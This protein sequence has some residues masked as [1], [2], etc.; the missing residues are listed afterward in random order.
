MTWLQ[1]PGSCYP[2]IALQVQCGLEHVQRVREA[3]ARYVARTTPMTEQLWAARAPQ[4]V[5]ARH[6]NPHPVGKEVVML[7]APWPA[8]TPGRQANPLNPAAL[9]P[10]IMV[11]GRRDG[12]RWK[13][14]APRRAPPA[15]LRS[16]APSCDGP[17]TSSADLHLC[18]YG[19]HEH[20]MS[21]SHPRWDR[22]GARWPDTRTVFPRRLDHPTHPTA[23][24]GFFCPKGW[25]MY[26]KDGPC[27]CI[28]G[29]RAWRWWEKRP[30]PLYPNPAP[31]PTGLTAVAQRLRRFA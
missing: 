29:V 19:T 18:L 26:C 21:P 30:S 14:L 9:L 20:P 2:G 13:R 25:Y 15:P 31:R 23:P 12:S 7:P 5:A 6:P 27:R 3:R 28:K 24:A 4:V 1:S 11:A 16:G 17:F 22:E 10:L 8:A